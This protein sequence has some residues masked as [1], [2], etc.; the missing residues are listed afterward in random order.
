MTTLLWLLL[1]A[2]SAGAPQG[3]TLDVRHEHA[4]GACEGR[5]IVSEESVRYD[6]LNEDHARHWSYPDIE[7]FEIVSIS[8]MRIHTYESEGAM[9]LW[10]DRD[11]RFQLEDESLGGA[12]FAFLEQRSPRP[13][14]TRIIPDSLG[15]GGVSRTSPAVAVRTLQELPV[16]HDHLFG[17]CEGTLNITEN[18]IIYVT[19]NPN[20]SR[21]WR[22]ADVESFA[23]TG[24]FDLR[25]STRN[26][27]FH[28]DLK[29]PLNKA[30]YQHIWN[31][32][33]E[34]QIQTYRGNVQ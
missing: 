34:P 21:I 14:R 12:V 20:D 1:T 13:V 18:A 7:S 16:R 6:T 19:E 4:F 15:S 10:R 28:F 24:D 33:H 25:V 31:K 32:V 8:E 29:L 9:K 23:S 22:L 27:T 26:E 5:L 17:G 3:W 2:Q 30:T 11:F